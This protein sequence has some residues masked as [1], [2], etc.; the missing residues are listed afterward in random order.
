MP[1]RIR[2]CDKNV[3]NTHIVDIRMFMIETL[4]FPSESYTANIAV[5][6]VLYRST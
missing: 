5:F 1:I 2:R 6:G 4:P 3:V